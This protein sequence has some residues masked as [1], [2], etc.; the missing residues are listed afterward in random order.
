MHEAG[1]ESRTNV[2]ETKALGSDTT[3]LR[4]SLACHSVGQAASSSGLCGGKPF[5]VPIS[6]EGATPCAPS[7]ASPRPVHLPRLPSRGPQAVIAVGMALVHCARQCSWGAVVP[8]SFNTGARGGWCPLRSSH[9]G[10]A[11][12]PRERDTPY[13]Q[14]PQG[15][16]PRLSTVAIPL[17]FLLALLAPA[18]LEVRWGGERGG[19]FLTTAAHHWMGNT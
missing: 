9:R 1:F 4:T 17:Q 14:C 5:P 15:W 8:L 19:G 16:A 13:H 11:R 12:S 10:N 2:P 7:P 3:L 18:A 6:R